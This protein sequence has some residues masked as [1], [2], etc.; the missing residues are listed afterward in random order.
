MLNQVDKALRLHIDGLWSWM[1]G[2]YAYIYI[3][4]LNQSMRGNYVEM[5]PW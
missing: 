2:G 1:A 5:F 3:H 4:Y